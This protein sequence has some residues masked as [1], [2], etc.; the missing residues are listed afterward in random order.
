MKNL[1]IFQNNKKIAQ[2]LPGI[3]GVDRMIFE[4]EITDESCKKIQNIL[5]NFRQVKPNSTE[6]DIKQL[7]EENGFVVLFEDELKR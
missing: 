5:V 1:Y 7:F 6:G 2:I 3:E 4:N